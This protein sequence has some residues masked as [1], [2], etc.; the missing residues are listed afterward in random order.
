MSILPRKLR[1]VF[2]TAVLWAGAWILASVPV[3]SIVWLVGG[4]SRDLLEVLR[5]GLVLWGGFGAM[6]G[7]AFGVFLMLAERNRTLEQLTKTRVAVWGGIGAALFPAV[8][9]A[10]IVAIP[11]FTLLGSRAQQAGIGQFL[12][13]CLI[14]GA[15]G[16][17]V[18]TTHLSL[19][20]RLPAG[21]SR[22]QLTER[23]AT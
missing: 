8:L 23:T 1:A 14:N 18:A 19:A 7:I 12:T 10:L 21:G 11:D 5:I 16:A 6:N 15:L 13:S 17:A 22:P 2:T 3:L 4:R 9:F 20:R